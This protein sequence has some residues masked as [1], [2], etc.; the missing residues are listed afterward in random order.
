MRVLRAVGVSTFFLLVLSVIAF[1]TGAPAARSAPGP[2]CNRPQARLAAS[3]S[4]LGVKMQQ[5]V[6]SPLDSN[7]WNLA[8][9]SCSHLRS[10][11]EI[12]MVAEFE[13]CTANSPTPIGIFRPGANGRWH[14]TYSWSGEPPVYELA[15]H[16]RALEGRTPVY[17]GGPLC[18]P[19][20]SRPWS[21]RWNG[22]RWIIDASY[23]EGRP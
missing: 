4:P 9:I 6:G 21:V 14:L 22:R 2:S 16:G 11:T 17:N 3:R 1:A 5:E 12:D 19:V 8:Y 20:G 7:T 10:S 15:L 13:C 18:C 23:S